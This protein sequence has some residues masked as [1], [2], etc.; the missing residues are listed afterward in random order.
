[1][2]DLVCRGDHMRQDMGAAAGVALE[3]EA[4]ASRRREDQVVV[5]EARI[6][7]LFEVE[8]G[9]VH[10]AVHVDNRNALAVEHAGSRIDVIDR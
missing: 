6:D 7:R 10:V 4:S 2:E 8:V 9:G 3:V 5:E 1:M